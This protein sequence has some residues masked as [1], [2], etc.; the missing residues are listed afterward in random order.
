MTNFKRGLLM[1]FATGA[2][3]TL[4]VLFLWGGEPS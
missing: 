4:T 2:L 3:L 1:G